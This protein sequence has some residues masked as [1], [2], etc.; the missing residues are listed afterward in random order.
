VD[1]GV[2]LLQERHMTPFEHL[3]FALDDP[4]AVSRGLI[5]WKSSRVLVER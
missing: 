1:R 3:C 2:R 4:R 5:G